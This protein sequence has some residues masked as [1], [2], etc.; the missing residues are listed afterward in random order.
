MLRS[1]SRMVAV[2]LG[3]GS[4]GVFAGAATASAVGLP[5]SRAYE[6]V[7][8]PDK[9]GGDVLA[10]SARIRVAAD[11]SAVGF[12][13]LVGIGNVSGTGVAA[14][15][16]SV[17]TGARDSNGW[18]THG[19]T[20]VQDPLTLQEVVAT[21]PLYVGDFAEDLRQG[22][23][24]A[25]SPLTD[26][27]SVATVSNL[28][29][30]EDLRSDRGGTSRLISSCPLCDA[31]S[32]PLP[33]LPEIAPGLVVPVYAGASPDFETIAFESRYNLTS[34]APAQLPQCATA[35][36]LFCRVRLYQWDHGQVSLAGLV[37]SG[38]DL[39]C[40][41]TGQ[42]CV[43]AST[44]I[45]GQGTGAQTGGQVAR[46]PL[47]VVSNDGA[48]VFFT[49]PSDE[50]VL[51]L[52]S[53][54]KLYVRTANTTT[55]W[56]DASERTDCAGDPTCGGNRAPDPAPDTFK[57]ASYWTASADGSRVFF[58][59]SEA[60]TD[61]APAGGDQNL[62]MYDT[63]KP[64]SNP[65]NLTYLNADHERG[66]ASNDVQ[67]VIGSSDDGRYVYFITTGQLVAGEPLLEGNRGVFVWHE[68][69]L[70]YIGK[71][72][73]SESR[74]LLATGTDY[75]LTRQ[76]ARV[77]PDGKHLLLSAHDGSG[78]SP[79]YDHG[80]CSVDGSGC[81]EF[82]VYSAETHR[83]VCAS[84]TPDGAA[85]T[86]DAVVAVRTNASVA[87]TTWHRNR[88]ISDDGTGVFFT[89]GEA[90]VPEDTNGKNDVYE[91]NVPT[92][93]VRLITSGI[94]KSDSYFMDASPSG[95]DIFF[96]TR[97]RLVGWD[98][99]TSY[100]LYDARVNGGFPEPVVDPARCAG[101]ACQGMLGSPAPAPRIG[102]DSVD[103]PGNSKATL[104]PRPEKK[105]KKG[106]V[107]RRIRGKRK[108][109]KRKRQHATKRAVR[110]AGIQ[111]QRRI[112]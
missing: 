95:N 97:E 30:R 4:L 34:D 46:R 35:S 98:T 107:K 74:D 91:Y 41:G 11:G 79:D 99:D 102:T 36:V 88:P 8:P 25:V 78:L 58:T 27:P 83:L 54:G 18:S 56:L 76:Q 17:R 81:R 85:A 87:T 9:N 1:A 75:G 96:L 90:L 55:D 19:I 59:T 93:S 22:V 106:F 64:A 63:S 60:L 104:P 61:D 5:D 40:G 103:G 23:F 53:S 62:Y 72:L 84:C 70:A 31:A 108:C 100:D 111:H 43:A 82:Y 26:A 47:H 51:G 6:L 50:A 32:S 86:A 37:P 15:Y 68:G 13:S 65:H 57:P 67:G 110:R 38:G 89:T 3:L 33:P 2:V 109:V 16:M 112:K 52:A 12:S 66:D 28:Y 48:R 69:E 92:G 77:T 80:T 94:D 14:D 44:S 105:C 42:P 20:P 71:I 21:D 101:S 49:V 10:D 73:D 29:R 7:S 45:A 24:R 39:S